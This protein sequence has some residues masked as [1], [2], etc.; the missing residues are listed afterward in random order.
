MRSTAECTEEGGRSYD[1]QRAAQNVAWPSAAH[2]AMMQCVTSN[3][4]VCRPG[5]PDGDLLSFLLT[6]K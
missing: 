6:C 1:S 4:V 3:V 2:A 5:L